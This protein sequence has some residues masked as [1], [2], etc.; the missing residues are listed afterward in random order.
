L[1]PR[2]MRRLRRRSASKIRD[3]HR[4]LLWIEIED[5]CRFFAF[6]DRNSVPNF[7]NRWTNRISNLNYSVRIDPFWG[8]E[9]RGCRIK[10]RI[11]VRCWVS[12]SHHHSLRDFLHSFRL[13]RDCTCPTNNKA[14][15]FIILTKQ[16]AARFSTH[17]MSFIFFPVE[18]SPPRTWFK[19]RCLH[20]PKKVF[21]MEKYGTPCLLWMLDRRCVQACWLPLVCPRVCH[22][23]R[24]MSACQGHPGPATRGWADGELAEL[25]S[26]QCSAWWVLVGCSGQKISAHAHYSDPYSPSISWCHQDQDDFSQQ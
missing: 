22:K 23:H 9:N 4:I 16:R 2:K 24:A 21:P 1:A 7:T 3:D 6:S 14:L 12:C 11:R 19:G 17:Y 26:S 10:W 8:H 5:R 18:I 13:W 20:V 15:G 25:G